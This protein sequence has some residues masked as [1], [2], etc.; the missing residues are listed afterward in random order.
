MTSLLCERK[1]AR[2]F[3]VNLPPRPNLHAAARLTDEVNPTSQTMRQ[4]MF[5][6][7]PL[8]PGLSLNPRLDE[9]TPAAPSLSS[10]QRF[11]VATPAAPSLSSNQGFG[12]AIPAVPAGIEPSALPPLDKRSRSLVCP[13][14]P[15]SA[16]DPGATNAPA[17]D[18]V[19]TDYDSLSVLED[20]Q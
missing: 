18:L 17:S 2:P 1:A 15:A 10:N 20:A 12:D 13:G 19:F 16:C 5:G 3:D 7:A 9:A 6:D 8:L 11:D 4:R 14:S